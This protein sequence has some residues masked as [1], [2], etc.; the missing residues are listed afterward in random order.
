MNELILPFPS[1]D[2]SQNGR[3]HW[4]RKAAATKSAREEARILALS[5]GWNASHGL[6]DGRLHLWWDYYTPSRRRYDDDNLLGRCK[7]Y[8]DGIADALGIDDSR[9]VSHPWIKG[10]ARPDGE[11]RVRI[12]GGPA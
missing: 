10:V 4:A 5:A 3:V 9:F 12:T 6:P 7:A 1:P 2:L 8:R 11:V